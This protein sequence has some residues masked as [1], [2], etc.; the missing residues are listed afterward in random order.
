MFQLENK[1]LTG[2]RSALR[3]SVNFRWISEDTGLPL[4]SIYF[5]N[6]TGQGPR[7][8]KIGRRYWVT[9]SDYELWLSDKL[10]TD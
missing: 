2:K 9:R 10:S 3:D 8:F 7:A 6:K 4:S 5:F 1:A